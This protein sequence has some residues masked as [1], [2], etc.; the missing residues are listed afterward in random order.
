MVFNLFIFVCIYL[1]EVRTIKDKY[2]I[3]THVAIIMDGN[4]RWATKRGMSRNYGHY[5]GCKTIK[6]IIEECYSFGIKV[7]S[8]YAFS[9]E[10]WKRPVEEINCI[11]EYL[12]EFLDKNQQYF[13]SY[14]IRLMV[15]GDIERLPIK[16]KNN[17]MAVCEKTKNN[18]SLILNIGIN[19][20][21]QQEILRAINNIYKDLSK[22]YNK[23]QVICGKI[24]NKYLYTFLLP[25]V[26]LLIRTS[27]E[28]RLSN[29]M[30]W[31]IS[32]AEIIFYKK[33]WPS[34]N[35]H[36]LLLCIKEYS[37]RK[38]RYGGLGYEENRN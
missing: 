1:I 30:L 17:I 35:R 7:L 18:K 23:T 22:E 29:F 34:F 3:P 12:N 4:G 8:L 9:T 28:Q 21:S 27:G 25:E 2:K 15:M 38:R 24:L 31:Q 36:D 26:D 14:N 37:K 13:Y 11:F 20:G 19:Y 5:Q 33:Y 16:L 10:N 32:Y 6:N